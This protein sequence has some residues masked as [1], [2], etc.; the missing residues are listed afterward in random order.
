MPLLCE[1]GT[2]VIPVAEDEEGQVEE[3]IVVEVVEDVVIKY[4]FGGNVR[5][6]QE[7]L[8]RRRGVCS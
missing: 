2:V 4:G 3:E 7:R 6:E 8:G 1:G 5:F